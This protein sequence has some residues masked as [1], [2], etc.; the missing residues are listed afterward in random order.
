MLEFEVNDMTCGHCASTITKAVQAT[1]PG[2]QLDIKLDT[3]R[4]RVGGADDAMAIE[5]AIREAGYSP[6]RIA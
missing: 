4:V 1:A 2:A 6:V 3:H 5:T